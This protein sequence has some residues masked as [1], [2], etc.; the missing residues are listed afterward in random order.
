MKYFGSK[1]SN[2]MIMTKDG[3]LICQNVPISRTGTQDYL[4][5]ELYG[6]GVGDIVKVN[7]E[8]EEVFSDEAIASFEGKPFTDEHPQE[9]VDPDNFTLYAKGHVQNV[10]R[11]KGK[12][13]NN[14]VA[15]IFVNDKETIDKIQNGKR[16]ISCGYECEDVERDGELYQTNIRGNHIALVDRGR[17]G[18]KVA[19]RD[20]SIQKGESI[21]ENQANEKVV[22]DNNIINKLL[23]YLFKK[24]TA[25]VVADKK[26]E[27]EKKV[28]Y[29]TK[30]EM[31]KKIDEL[32][33][34]FTKKEEKEEVKKEDKKD[35]CGEDKK[36]KKDGEVI[37][38]ED[39]EPTI[40][41]VLNTFN[42]L[43]AKVKDE[44][45]KKQFVD[46]LSGF[47]DRGENPIVKAE[48][49]INDIAIN[50][51]MDSSKMFEEIQKAYDARNPHINQ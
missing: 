43:I 48:K 34:L 4:D 38:A 42:P 51:K 46:S 35:E 25:E 33:E 31:D 44:E 40:K 3:F 10:R 7:R 2:N 27:E 9:L 19:I 29:I 47:M 45:L 16:E 17:A 30:E 49:E 8:E 26:D 18:S 23:D 32:K 37:K 24:D 41:D 39:K 12:F 36:D 13:N 11:G 21:M 50:N 15:D 28:E 14:L 22:N 20:K 5:I 6:N 1:I